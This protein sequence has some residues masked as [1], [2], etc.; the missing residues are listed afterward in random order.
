ML[1]IDS[2][3]YEGRLMKASFGRTKYCK[4]FL[5]ETQCMNKECPYQHI[6]SDNKEILS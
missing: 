4:F 2:F 1:S 5:K 6:Y 3:V